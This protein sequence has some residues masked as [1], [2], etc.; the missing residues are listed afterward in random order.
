MPEFDQRPASLETSAQPSRLRPLPAR[1]I[2]CLE[3]NSFNQWIYTKIYHLVTNEM[4]DS[5]NVMV[6]VHKV[7][8]P[9]VKN[10]IVHAHIARDF[11]N[12]SLYVTNYC[13][14]MRCRKLALPVLSLSGDL[15]LAHGQLLQTLPVPGITV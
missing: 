3:K 11:V 13:L 4:M 2:A 8:G 6:K 7:P 12:G 10:C 15:C 5:L 1:D 9:E 14:Q